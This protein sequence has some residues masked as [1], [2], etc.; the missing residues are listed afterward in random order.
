M[1]SLRLLRE[2][3]SLLIASRS[4]ST[5]A[6]THGTQIVNLDDQRTVV[7]VQGETL[8]PYLQARR[9]GK[10]LARDPCM[11]GRRRGDRPTSQA[12]AATVPALHA[13]RVSCSSLQK[14]ISNDASKLVPGAPPIYACVLTPQVGRADKRAASRSMPPVAVTSPFNFRVAQGRI[15]TCGTCAQC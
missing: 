15:R 11:L 13:L 2:R 7:K 5:T 10:R 3:G 4:L 1:L 8:L 6:D 14:I 12:H 9:L